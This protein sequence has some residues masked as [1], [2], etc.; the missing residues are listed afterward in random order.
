MNRPANIEDCMDGSMRK[1][2]DYI[3]KNEEKQIRAAS[4]NVNDMKTNRTITKT[5]KQK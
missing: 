1:L 5:R 2:E 3:I 4:N